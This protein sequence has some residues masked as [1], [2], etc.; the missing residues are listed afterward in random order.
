VIYYILDKEGR[1]V[2]VESILEWAPWFEDAH[3]VVALT[4][5]DEGRSVSTV[6]LGINHAFDNGPPILWETMLFTYEKSEAQDRS[7]GSLEQAEA[8][9]MRMVHAVAARLNVPVPPIEFLLS[10]TKV[11]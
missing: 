3:R 11:P 8:M 6:F 9:H 2:A 7:S 4:E 5:I 10:H 1:P